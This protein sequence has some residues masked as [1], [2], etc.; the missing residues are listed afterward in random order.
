[1]NTV[2]IEGD[3][4]SVHQLFVELKK[5]KGMIKQD[6]AK[7]ALMQLEAK[8]Y[9]VASMTTAHV[10]NT[11]ND[12]KNEIL[13]A[14]NQIS[15]QIA[16]GFA[17]AQAR[18]TRNFQILQSHL[19]DMRNHLDDK[20]SDVEQRFTTVGAQGRDQERQLKDFSD[21]V[22]GNM[23]KSKNTRATLVYNQDAIYEKIQQLQDTVVHGGR[24]MLRQ[25]ATHS[26][27][28]AYLTN[29]INATVDLDD[30]PTSGQTDSRVS[31]D[32]TV[33]SDSVVVY[34][35]PLMLSTRVERSFEE[36]HTVVEVGDLLGAA[37]VHFALQQSGVCRC[38]VVRQTSN[39]DSENVKIRVLIRESYDNK[40]SK[41]A[42]ALCQISPTASANS[43]EKL[44]ET[45]GDLCRRSP[46]GDSVSRHLERAALARNLD[47]IKILM[48]EQSPNEASVDVARLLL[49]KRCAALASSATEGKLAV[50]TLLLQYIPPVVASTAI[51]FDD[52][53][54]TSQRGSVDLRVINVNKNSSTYRLLAILFQA[55]IKFATS[56]EAVSRTVFKFPSGVMMPF[57][58]RLIP[59]FT[60]LK[61]SF[62][63]GQVMMQNA[64]VGQQVHKHILIRF[65]STG[66]DVADDDAQRFRS[67]DDY[68]TN[69]S[70]QVATEEKEQLVCAADYDP[71]LNVT[72]NPDS[73][74]P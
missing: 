65:N 51:S 54:V 6:D 28:L 26:D 41:L 49:A 53:C 62:M 69:T 60:T 43:S 35:T 29:L 19:F 56:H 16:A 11:S 17:A 50:F 44:S 23:T 45:L 58:S 14:M 4:S 27:K 73:M 10:Q 74:H 59:S 13:R 55:I 1:M 67:F 2:K 33:V 42:S 5:I 47:A 48:E 25:S 72:H 40:N 70:R 34:S 24:E 38:H 12:N 30:D 39:E 15:Q 64:V 31:P 3:S 36:A 22:Q 20:M 46:R 63:L 71:L 37:K 18:E 7:K 52:L 68:D 57:E 66:D 9:E 61:K 21:R 8:I 32:I